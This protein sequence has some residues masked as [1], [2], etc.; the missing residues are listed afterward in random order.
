MNCSL[1]RVFYRTMFL[2]LAFLLFSSVADK[3]VDPKRMLCYLH[4][5]LVVLLYRT[6]NY[7]INICTVSNYLYG[8]EIVS[9]YNLTAACVVL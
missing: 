2:F 3:D 7:C 8:T 4:R 9:T 6:H 5:E 1:R